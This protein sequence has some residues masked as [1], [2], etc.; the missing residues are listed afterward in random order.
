[1]IIKTLTSAVLLSAVA[2]AASA[3]VPTYTV[4]GLA[5]CLETSTGTSPGFVRV[6]LAPGTYKASVVRS[7]LANNPGYPDVID[8]NVALIVDFYTQGTFAQGKPLKF[9]VSNPN[10]S[11]VWVYYVD[12][13]CA[14]NAGSTVV[15]FM[16]Q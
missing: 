6:D 13:F 15:K 11:P 3:G 4:D 12:S 2:T 8:S 7:T 16:P 9:T 10:G 5:N 14:D 1:M